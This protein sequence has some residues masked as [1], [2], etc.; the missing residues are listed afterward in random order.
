[1]NGRLQDKVAL[2][3]GSGRGIGRAIAMKLAAEGARVVINDLD[4]ARPKRPCRPSVPPAAK[5]WPVPAA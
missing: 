3:T 1:M 4:S 5:P 2:V